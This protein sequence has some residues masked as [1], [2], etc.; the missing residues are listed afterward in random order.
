MSARAERPVNRR[1]RIVGS[2]P[3]RP[4]YRWRRERAE[5]GGGSF[6]AQRRRERKLEKERQRRGKRG[7]K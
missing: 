2:K 6:K 3:G 4:E 1:V 7:D 5:G